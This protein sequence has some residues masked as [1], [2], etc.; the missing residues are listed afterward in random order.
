[1]PKPDSAC[2]CYT[3]NVHHC[4]E[5]YPPHGQGTMSDEEAKNVAAQKE[6]ATK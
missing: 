3:H 6:G 5:C 2:H 1:M 4:I